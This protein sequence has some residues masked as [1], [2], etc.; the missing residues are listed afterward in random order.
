[1]HSADTVPNVAVVSCVHLG[2][3]GLVPLASLGP[4]LAAHLHSVPLGGGALSTPDVEAGSEAPTADP[5]AVASLRAMFDMVGTDTVSVFMSWLRSHGAHIVAGGSANPEADIAQ[6]LAAGGHLC[7]HCSSMLE[8]SSCINCGQAAVDLSV[9]AAVVV[10]DFGDLA[11]A[12]HLAAPHLGITTPLPA[13]PPTGAIGVGARSPLSPRVPGA[14]MT[15]CGSSVLLLVGHDVAG[16]TP[17]AAAVSP[18]PAAPAPVSTPALT[19]TPGGLFGAPAQVGLFGAPAF[20]GHGGFPSG[21][22]V[23]EAFDGHRSLQLM[24]AGRQGGGT[25]SAAAPVLADAV[26]TAATGHVT[27]H[28]LRLDDQ[29]PATEP[30]TSSSPAGAGLRLAEVHALTL[31]REPR[32]GHGLQVLGGG[33]SAAA[34]RARQQQMRMQHRRSLGGPHGS[35]TRLKDAGVMVRRAFGEPT[36]AIT[37]EFWVRILPA[38]GECARGTSWHGMLRRSAAWRALRCV[39]LRC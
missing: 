34:D 37:V 12:L 20:A 38:P 18:A 25:S 15:A 36:P 6:A 39:A 22:A 1:V 17:A 24:T 3:V 21:V 10:E 13:G 5:E 2:E 32:L 8:D 23:A 29:P 9:L 4:A 35:T 7:I 26:P 31:A 28:V 27:L 30:G 33:P 11:A 14:V 19:H 16:S